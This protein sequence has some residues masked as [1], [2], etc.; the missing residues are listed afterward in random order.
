M[1][2]SDNV[3]TVSDGAETSLKSPQP[4]NDAEEAQQNQ[5][6][7]DAETLTEKPESET[8]LE[9]TKK[10]RK[11]KESKLSKRK[12]ER[13]ALMA[14]VPK[15]DQDGISYTKIQIRRM[16]KRVK[17]GLTPVE[18]PQ[19]EQERLRRDAQLRKEEEAEL[20]GM[21]YIRDKEKD[22]TEMVE[23]NDSHE[24]AQDP[25]QEQDPVDHATD[26]DTDGADQKKS[27]AEFNDKAAES[28]INTEE[29]PKKKKCRGKPVPNDY[30]CQACKNE[31]SPRH[32]IYDCPKKVTMR[33]TNNI[34]KREKGIHDPD[35]KK[36][37][38]SGLPFDTKR[39]DLENMFQSCG[40]M[41]HC[42][43][44]TFPDTGRCKGQAFVTFDSENAAS[45]ARGL[46]GTPVSNE[47]S[48]GD[49]KKSA[50]QKKK[51]LKLK[52]TKVLNRQKTKRGSRSN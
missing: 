27:G 10:K 38:V 28:S 2:K 9:S 34:S 8:E 3:E 39:K 50:E 4:T 12:E 22:E 14:K 45:L 20:A 37:F 40:K 35:E 49:G 41:L 23:D 19:E 25:D 26:K 6:E 36:V 48:G 32:W 30:I 7:T 1:Q 29:P 52:V 15:V 47:A 46:N 44:L 31:H 21:L 42:K 13:E 51:E 18:T 33:G 17:K 11:R 24:D 43:I 16:M 5:A